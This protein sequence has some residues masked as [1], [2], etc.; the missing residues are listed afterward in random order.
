MHIR[1]NISLKMQRLCQVGKT[2]FSFF[3]FLIFSLFL[4]HHSRSLSC[5]I[6]KQTDQ[7]SQRAETESGNVPVTGNNRWPVNGVT[8]SKFKQPLSPSLCHAQSP[9]SEIK[10]RAKEKQK[11]GIN[12]RIKR[13]KYKFHHFLPFHWRQWCEATPAGRRGLSF[14]H[15]R[16]RRFLR[17]RWGN[18]GWGNEPQELETIEKK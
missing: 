4:S 17:T 12:Y 18:G 6:H 14:V 3:I 9:S 1:A 5:I 10:E 8:C 16:F 11:K 2:G 15:S 13:K 7:R